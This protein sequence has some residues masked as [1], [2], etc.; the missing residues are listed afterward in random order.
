M[1]ASAVMD[2]LKTRERED[3]VDDDRVVRGRRFGRYLVLGEIGKGGMGIVYRAYDPELNRK[4]A[5]KV[6]RRAERDPERVA[7]ARV[8]LQREAQTL[9]RLS[10]RNVVAVYDVGTRDGDVFLAMELCEG[11]D[12]QAW[13]AMRQRSTSE[14]LAVMVQ[15]GEGLAA[16][17]DVGIV[18]RD[19][20]P[21]NVL[22]SD[23]GRISVT[24][25]GLA[26]PEPTVDLAAAGRTRTGTSRT[27]DPSESAI[28][29]GSLFDLTLTEEG[30]AVGTPAYMAPEQHAGEPADPRGDQYAFCLALWEA[31]Y[32]KRPFQGLSSRVLVDEK[33]LGIAAPPAARGPGGAV[34]RR[35]RKALVRGLQVDPSRRFPRLGALLS[36]LRPRPHRARRVAAP[37][38]AIAVT[39][40]A[41]SLAWGMLKAERTGPCPAA[42][43]RLHGAWDDDAR[44]RVL[45]AF[46]ATGAPHAP[47]TGDAVVAMLDRRASAWTEMHQDACLATWERGEQSQHLLDLRMACLEDQRRQLAATTRV[48]GGADRSVVDH[49][50]AMVLALPEVAVCADIAR[51]EGAPPPPDPETAEIVA[52]ARDGLAEVNAARRAGRHRDALDRADQLLAETRDL[53][54]PATRAEI[55]LAHAK[56]LADDGRP[57]RAIEGFEHAAIVARRAGHGRTEAEAWSE[58]S[59]VVGG[60]MQEADRG[61]FYGEL[62]L[63]TIAALGGDEDLLATARLELGEV[64]FRAGNDEAAARHIEAA[65]ELREALYGRDHYLVAETLG[66]L[67]GPHFRGGEHERAARELERAIGIYRDVFGDAHPRLAAPIGNLGLVLASMGRTDEAIETMQ[68]ART[69][70]LAAFGPE[71]PGIAA[72]DDSIATALAKAGR[73]RDAIAHYRTAIDTFE[74][75]LGP[76][77][78]AIAAPLL[79]LG[80]AWLHL[81]RP[82]DARAPLERARAAAHDADLPAV[83]RADIDFALARAIAP[84][85]EHERS[86]MLARAAQAVYADV[87]GPTDD[88]IAAIEAFLHGRADS[89]PR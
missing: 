4:V 58:L 42:E 73:T 51:L 86:G 11:Q 80:T 62:A 22:V 49:A 48:L 67:A 35:V 39:G 26:R 87:L 14:V 81:G 84:A 43:S 74:R 16:A 17:H 34:P 30:R 44:A 75:T 31:L 88:R 13:L 64:E 5:L 33:R 53:P 71:H 15:A 63:A 29:D 79:G 8:R 78:P 82:A 36:E 24:D 2:T 9:A 77:H 25:F 1:V 65:L 85:G 56:L 59:R 7:V 89:P 47:A 6:L 66:R 70:L 60:H 52:V 54:H 19:F 50:A 27:V 28:G 18:H 55:E 46:E 45:D 61:R 21:S 32:G 40:L 41:G 68:R 69:I 23:D 57:E 37:L 10:H 72:A 12:L 83:E 3:D 20:K 76:T 38:V